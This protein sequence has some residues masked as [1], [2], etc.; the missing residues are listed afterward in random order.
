MKYP[1]FSTVDKK[2]HIEIATKGGL[3]KRSKEAQ[4]AWDEADKIKEI[5][6][7]GAETHRS[8]AD[9]YKVSRMTI[10]RIINS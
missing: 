6:E 9:R 10:A 3:K 7:A 8:L 2:R 1:Y 5:Y 4:K